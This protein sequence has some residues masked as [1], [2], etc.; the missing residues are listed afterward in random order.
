MNIEWKSM[1][2]AVDVL[3]IFVSI[4]PPTMTFFDNNKNLNARHLSYYEVQIV[5]FANKQFRFR[6]KLIA[7]NLK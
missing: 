2:L 7:R 3:S 5:L 6:N 4:S 1:S